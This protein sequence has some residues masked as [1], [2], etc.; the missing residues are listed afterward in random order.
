[1]L[2]QQP[3]LSS[4]LVFGLEEVSIG[5]EDCWSR[6]KLELWVSVDRTAWKYPD[7]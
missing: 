7:G 4:A 5:L 1:M 6:I 2:Q 3:T